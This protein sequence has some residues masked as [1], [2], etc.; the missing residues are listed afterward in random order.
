MVGIATVFGVLALASIIA[1][2]LSFFHERRLYLN[3]LLLGFSVVCLVLFLLL[4][5]SGTPEQAVL[6][7]GIFIG[8]PLMMALFTVIFVH[9]GI[10][11]LRREGISFKN[12]L[13]LLFPLVVWAL[14]AVFLELVG[15]PALAASSTGWL[16]CLADC[17]I[18]FTFFSLM[19]YSWF[20]RIIPKRGTIDYIIV[21]GAGLVDGRVPTPL[22][23]ARLDKA[24]AVWNAADGKATFIVSGGQ[25]GDEQVSEAHAMA[26]YLREQGIPADQIIEEDQSCNTLQN[27]RYSKQIVDAHDDWKRGVFVTNDFHV[28]RAATYARQVSLRADGVGCRTARWYWP[29]AFVREY[30]AIIVKHL[31]LPIF[32]I[33]LWAL[34]LVVSLL[35]F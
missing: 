8:L 5:T 12:A 20:Y 2:L 11:T 9:A 19:V 34:L 16:A 26:G 23:A 3:A 7:V 21:L 30:A 28:F 13:A 17:Y 15:S 18:V 22:L 35:P 27:M 6:S 29:S 33:A 31:G 1:F 32:V 10:T 14:F 25:G 24:R 4:A